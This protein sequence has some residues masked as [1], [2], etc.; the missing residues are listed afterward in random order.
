[1]IV[2]DIPEW[3]HELSARTVNALRQV[4]DLGVRPRHAAPGA[5]RSYGLWREQGGYLI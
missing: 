4:L 2:T 3:M 5:I 1:M